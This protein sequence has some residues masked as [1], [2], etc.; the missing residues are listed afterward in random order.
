M[1]SHVVYRE[2][3]NVLREML[4]NMG[5]SKG[6]LFF[7]QTDKTKMLEEPC[8]NSYYSLTPF[9]VSQLSYDQATLYV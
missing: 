8:C 6:I 2:V 5:I 3:V 7:F 4:P 1:I 9:N